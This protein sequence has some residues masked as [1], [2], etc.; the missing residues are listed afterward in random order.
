MTSNMMEER[1]CILDVDG[2][3]TKLVNVAKDLLKEIK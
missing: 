3:K 1:D 2:K